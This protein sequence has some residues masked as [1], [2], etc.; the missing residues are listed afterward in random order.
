MGGNS[1]AC[2]GGD[3]EGCTGNKG[4]CTGSKSEGCTGGQEEGCTGGNGGQCAADESCCG[5][6]GCANGILNTFCPCLAFITGG[7][8]KGCV[9][10]AFEDPL[11]SAPLGVARN[12]V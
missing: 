2:T 9:G 12:A 1:G 10:G 6:C 11:M 8:G 5:V 3:E 4:G 7:S